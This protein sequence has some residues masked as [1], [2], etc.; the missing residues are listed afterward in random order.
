MLLDVSAVIQPKFN[1][2]SFTDLFRAFVVE[3]AHLN[4]VDGLVLIIT[5]L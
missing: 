4:K 2:R 5:H 3:F 1:I